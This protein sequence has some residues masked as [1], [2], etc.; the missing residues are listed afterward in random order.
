MEAEHCN[1]K[2]SKDEFTT[3]NYRISTNPSQ[4]WKVVT[5]FQFGAKFSSDHRKIKDI[6]L[7][8]STELAV[9]AGLSQSEVIALVL[10]TGYV[11]VYTCMHI[12]FVCVYVCMH[13]STC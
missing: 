13:I 1:R 6:N 12:T 5:D 9:S 8:K 2:D 4:E 7:L 10:Y 3:R 11:Y